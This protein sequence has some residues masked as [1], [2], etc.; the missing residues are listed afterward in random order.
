MLLSGKRSITKLTARRIADRLGLR[1]RERNF[2]LQL[3]DFNEEVDPQRRE[4]KFQTLLKS[5]KF[6]EAQPLVESQYELFQNSRAVLLL[7]LLS[8]KAQ[9]RSLDDFATKLSI[10]KSEARLFLDLLLKLKLVEKRGELYQRT[11]LALTTP[12]ETACSALS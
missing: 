6:R 1:E 11:A 12:A 7:E 4:H 10:S 8:T 5:K 3:V 9:R 2:F